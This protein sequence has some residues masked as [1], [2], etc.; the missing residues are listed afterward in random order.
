MNLRQAR[1]DPMNHQMH[2]TSGADQSPNINMNI[3]IA[4][5]IEFNI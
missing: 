3:Q 4:K 2:A 5:N 1:N